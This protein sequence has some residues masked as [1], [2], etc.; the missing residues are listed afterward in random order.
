LTFS[1]TDGLTVYAPMDVTNSYFLVVTN[2]LGQIVGWNM[3]WITPTFAMFSGTNSPVCVG[4][5]VTDSAFFP[6]VEGAD[7]IDSPGSWTEST[8]VPA[9][10]SS[11]VLLCLGLACLVGAGLTIPK[12][13]FPALG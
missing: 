9:E 3:N 8:P 2:S 1:F 4:C 11:V 7:I 12:K 10:P 5:T 6:N 13:S